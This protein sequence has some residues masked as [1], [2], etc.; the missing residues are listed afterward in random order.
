MKNEGVEGLGREEGGGKKG[1]WIAGSEGWK[2][3]TVTKLFEVSLGS[4]EEACRAGQAHT[5]AD[6]SF[7]PATPSTACGGEQALDLLRQLEPSDERHKEIPPKS[8]P[9]PPAC[10]FLWCS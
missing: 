10:W 7:V 6:E 8:A 5:L 4:G 9:S 3:R 2:G 1:G